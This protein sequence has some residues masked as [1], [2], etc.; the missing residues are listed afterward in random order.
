M[1]VTRTKTRQ[2]G[3]T[4][5]E[6]L[7]VTAILVTIFGIVT[8]A[9][10]KLQ[11]RNTSEV[12]KVDMTQQARDFVDQSVRDIHQAGY[13]P[14]RMIFGLNLAAAANDA[15]VAVG[16]QTLSSWQL[17]FEG[18][19]DGSGTVV[20]ETIRLVDK[21]NALVTSNAAVCPCTLQ[22]GTQT[23]AQELIGAVPTYYTQLGN[24]TNS[25]TNT[26]IFIGYDQNGNATAVLANVRSVRMTVNTQSPQVD[27][28]SKVAPVLSL[29]SQARI[30]NY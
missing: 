19:T 12:A 23:K 18:D 2:R 4:L 14:F 26:P 17:V 13:P 16:L 30:T 28:D 20:Q 15:R 24:V 7:I 25:T 11:R 1:K 21:N 5:V 3:F 22:R 27:L 9:I 8:Q 29:D 10:V 6:M